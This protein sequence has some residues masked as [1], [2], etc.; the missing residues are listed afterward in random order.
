MICTQ[1]CR[2]KVEVEFEYYP[3]DDRNYLVYRCLKCQHR[4]YPEGFPD[5]IEEF[6]LMTVQKRLDNL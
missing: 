6:V 3:D 2:G 1:N 5:S 4:N